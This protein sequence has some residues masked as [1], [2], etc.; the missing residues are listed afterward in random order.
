MQQGRKKRD[1]SKIKCFQCGELG[2]FVEIL[3]IWG[4]IGCAL[5]PKVGGGTRVRLI[6]KTQKGIWQ[7]SSGLGDISLINYFNVF[8]KSKLRKIK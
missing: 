7:I 1:L 3:C 2:H 4:S 5:A 8:P 6:Y